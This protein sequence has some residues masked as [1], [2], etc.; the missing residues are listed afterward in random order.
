MKVFWCNGG[1]HF[2]PEGPEERKA[3]TVL[4]R[5]LNLVE[6]EKESRSALPIGKGINKKYISLDE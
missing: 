5:A 3:L 4:A 1:L 2:Q 6:V